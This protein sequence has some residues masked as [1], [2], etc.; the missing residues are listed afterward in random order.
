MALP[1]FALVTSPSPKR[2]RW[3]YM[4]VAVASLVAFFLLYGVMED[5]QLTR[6]SVAERAQSNNVKIDPDHLP[7]AL[8]QYPVT[9][10][11]QTS[12]GQ[13]VSCTIR[14]LHDKQSPSCVI[15]SSPPPVAEA[16]VPSTQ[17]RNDAPVTQKPTVTEKPPVAVPAT[18]TVTPGDD[19]DHDRPDGRPTEDDGDEGDDGDGDGDNVDDADGRDGRDDG[20][21]GDDD[22]YRSVSGAM[23]LPASGGP[24]V[25]KD[26]TSSRGHQDKAR[27]SHDKPNGSRDRGGSPRSTLAMDIAKAAP[28]ADG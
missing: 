24:D 17:S 10:T 13:K 4:P 15:L 9:V 1:G 5:N 19:G 22:G 23:A 16:V 18:N 12:G 8:V 27:G 25:N 20:D 14:A 2:S 7:A 21:D 6:L 26:D 3:R 11:G 28:G